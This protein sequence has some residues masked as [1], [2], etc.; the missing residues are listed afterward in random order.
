V[1]PT[2]DQP[3]SRFAAGA[4]LVA[5]QR[6]WRVESARP[7]GERWLLRLS[8][9]D[10]RDAAAALAGAWLFSEVDLTRDGNKDDVEP[11]EDADRLRGEP[12]GTDADVIHDQIL[13]GMTV[14]TLGGDVVGHVTGVHHYP[15]QDLLD[16]QTPARGHVLIPFVSAIVTRVDSATRTLVVDP[17]TGL[18]GEPAGLDNDTKPE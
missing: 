9:I 18:I 2:T 13:V 1:A 10:G 5:G 3:Q 11:G 16:V 8:G 7:A 17:P 14:V 12:G 6:T 15:A 4:S